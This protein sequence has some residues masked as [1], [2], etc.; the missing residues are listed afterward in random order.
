MLG[1]GFLLPLAAPGQLGTG[2]GLPVPVPLSP[3]AIS[4]VPEPGQILSGMVGDWSGAEVYAWSWLSSSGGGW[5]P[6]AGAAGSG[7]AVADLALTEAERSRS[8]R[9]Q[10]T[11]S[12]AAGS[13]TAYSDPLTVPAAGGAFSAGF[14]AAFTV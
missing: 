5:V 9:L 14:S 10:V 2:T 8:F 11:A 13:R 7:V 3:P 4:G 1:L 6:V 12:N